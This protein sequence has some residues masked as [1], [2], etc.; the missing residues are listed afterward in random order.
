MR[1]VAKSWNHTFNRFYCLNFTETRDFGVRTAR[2]HYSAE[3][4]HVRMAR[5]R[6]AATQKLCLPSHAD[7]KT[8]MVP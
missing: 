5:L 7:W 3:Q 4:I 8:L 2:A 1:F 6:A